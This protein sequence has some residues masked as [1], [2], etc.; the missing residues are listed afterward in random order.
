MISNFTITAQAGDHQFIKA[1]S[2]Y[3]AIATRGGGGPV[4]IWEHE[5]RGRVP[6]DAAELVG[7]AG[8]VTDTDF[9]P[10]NENLIVTG[11]AD[12]CVRLWNIPENPKGHIKDPLATLEAHEKRVLFTT[13]HPSASNILA[14]ADFNKEAMVWDLQNSEDPAFKVQFDKPITDLKWNYDGSILGIYTKDHS[15]RLS[16][17]RSKEFG[18]ATFDKCHVGNKASKICFVENQNRLFSFGVGSTNSREV[19]V[20]DLRKPG[21]KSVH[22]MSI[23]RGSGAILPFYDEATHLILLGGKGDSSVKIMEAFGDEPH[24]LMYGNASFGE[25]AAGYCVV[26]KRACDVTKHEVFKMLRLTTRAVQPLSFRIPRKAGNFQSDIYG[27]G[28]RAPAAAMTSKEYLS[29]ENR[30]PILMSMDPAERKKEDSGKTRNQVEAELAAAKHKLR[31]LKAEVAL[32]ESQIKDS[33]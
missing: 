21:S 18:S 4:L 6:R 27:D 26:P 25:S 5:K 30:N 10:F 20:W 33:A 23:D 14:S 11:S 2:K 17:P 16:D 29:G 31:L 32:Y 19:R 12:C 13:F 8:N 28:V 24:C 22:K 1:N 7:H 9:H 3:M 15:I